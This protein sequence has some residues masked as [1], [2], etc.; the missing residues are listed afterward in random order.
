MK[1]RSGPYFAFTASGKSI[2]QPDL[3]NIVNAENVSLMT[4]TGKFAANRLDLL[5][6]SCTPAP[7]FDA[8]PGTEPGQSEIKRIVDV[9]KVAARDLRQIQKGRTA[10]IPGQFC[11]TGSFCQYCTYR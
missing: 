4:S 7:R 5:C 1:L 9:D 2:V 11:D 3:H 8:L 6:C 10:T